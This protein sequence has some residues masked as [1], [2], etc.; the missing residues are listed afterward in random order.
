MSASIARPI[1]MCRS[2]DEAMQRAKNG[3]WF[4]PRDPFVLK[5]ISFN[6]EAYREL[7]K[8]FRRPTGVQKFRSIEEMNAADEKLD[9]ELTDY[10]LN[11]DSNPEL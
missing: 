11:L 10:L 4:A 1:P 3:E 5:V 7:Q 9:R 6:F 2:L 8:G